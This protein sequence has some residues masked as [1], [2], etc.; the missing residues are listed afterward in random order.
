MMKQEKLIVVNKQ[1]NKHKERPKEESIPVHKQS[2][3]Y[4]P[5]SAAN[6]V[7][8]GDITCV[9]GRVRASNGDL[10]SRRGIGRSILVLKPDSNHLVGER[11]SAC[12]NVQ[13]GDIGRDLGSGLASRV[14]KTHETVHCGRHVNSILG[15]HSDGSRKTKCSEG[16]YF[17]ERSIG[18]INQRL[19]QFPSVPT[20]KL[21]TW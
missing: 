5:R 11:G 14:P 15:Q 17:L 18:S 6:A 20:A 1:I 7:D 12:E 8:V 21:L 10:S 9:T 16:V 4:G 2:I 3:S 13:E 19:Q